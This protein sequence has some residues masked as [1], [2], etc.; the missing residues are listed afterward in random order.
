MELKKF[1][2]GNWRD[3]ESVIHTCSTFSFYKHFHISKK[4]KTTN[5]YTW[6]RVPTWTFFAAQLLHQNDHELNLHLFQPC[7]FLLGNN[8]H[9]IKKRLHVVVKVSRLILVFVGSQQ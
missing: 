9:F 3:T 8:W 1:T 7:D 5:K 6:K 2:H 4:K